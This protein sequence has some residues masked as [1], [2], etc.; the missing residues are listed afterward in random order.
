MFDN[1]ELD[2]MM[3]MITKLMVTE[4]LRITR[5]MERAQ[6]RLSVVVSCV[7]FSASIMNLHFHFLSH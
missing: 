1:I 5:A 2:M 6:A 4:K 7:T 3:M